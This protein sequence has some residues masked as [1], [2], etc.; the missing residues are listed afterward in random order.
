[1]KVLAP[2]VH[3]GHVYTGIVYDIGIGKNEG[4][5]CKT[6][7]ALAPQVMRQETGLILFV[8]ASPK[9]PRQQ[10]FLSSRPHFF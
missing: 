10:W 3:L 8:V 2:I 4:D 5:C 6:M 9:E 7:L 1:L